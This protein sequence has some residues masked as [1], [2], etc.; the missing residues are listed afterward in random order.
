MS[1]TVLNFKELNDKYKK[2]IDEKTGGDQK[3]LKVTI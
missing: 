1:E 3:K 2:A